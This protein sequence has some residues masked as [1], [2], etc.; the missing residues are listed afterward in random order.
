M[1]ENEQLTLEQAL[2]QLGV[3]SE[4]TAQMASQ[5]D[6]R[7]Q[8]LSKTQDHTYDQA[9]IHLLQLMKNAHDERDKQNE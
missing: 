7:A 6:K 2:K 9:L 5:L 1:T 8:Q 4:K 3:P